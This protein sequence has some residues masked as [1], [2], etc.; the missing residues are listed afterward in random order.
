L[1]F[2]I[3]AKYQG[4]CFLNVLLDE[5]TPAVVEIWQY[6]YTKYTIRTLRSP[7]FYFLAI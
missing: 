7:T 3:F 5:I 1:H 6:M 2:I 4:D